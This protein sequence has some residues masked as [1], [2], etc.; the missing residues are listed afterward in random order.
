[1]GSCSPWIQRCLASLVCAVV[2]LPLAVFSAPGDPPAAESSPPPPAA[3]NQVAQTNAQELARAYVQLQELIRTTQLAIEQGRQETRQVATQTAGVLAKSL[4][5]IQET[6]DI[7]RARDLEEM[8]A[9]NQFMLIVVGTFAAMSLLSMLM[10]SYFQWRMS[11]GLAELSF[12]LPA[13]L[14]LG[15]GTAA[16]ALGPAQAR[17]PYL[18]LPET[19]EQRE[20]RIQAEERHPPPD[21]EPIA[22]ANR[23]ILNPLVPNAAF[24]RKRQIRTWKT[25]VIVG[26]ICAA[27]LAFLLYVATYGKMGF[28]VINR[29]LKI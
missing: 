7:Q 17:E 14:A 29:L 19:E 20:W 18:P 24:W 12:V 3:T 15:A 13:P 6:L 5:T 2:A 22:L 26:L 23:P 16:P 4:Q 9:S 11:D 10:M 1:M 25:T 8:R 27:V 21:L 28:E